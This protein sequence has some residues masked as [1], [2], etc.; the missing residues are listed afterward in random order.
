MQP[1]F[2]KV[3]EAGVA[4]ATFVEVECRASQALCQKYKAGAGGWPTLISF[5]KATGLEGARFVQKTQGMVCDELKVE[6][7]MRAHIEATL[8]RGA[9][10]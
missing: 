10:L 5:T 8:G 3:A 9:E 7:N 6:A 4:G 1:T 2:A